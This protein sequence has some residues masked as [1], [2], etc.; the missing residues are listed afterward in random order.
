[1]YM[2][3]PVQS[4][5]SHWGLLVSHK[6]MS[7]QMWQPSQGTWQD[8]VDCLGAG[9]E[10]LGMLEAWHSEV[11][12]LVREVCW[13]D[14]QINT[15]PVHQWW[16]SQG[17]RQVWVDHSGAGG[18]R[19]G[20]LEVWHVRSCLACGV[21]WC[22]HKTNGGGVSRFK[23]QNRAWRWRRRT[24]SGLTVWVMCVEKLRSKGHTTWSRCLHRR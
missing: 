23:H 19:L 6:T 8:R 7:V 12:R 21:C 22:Y 20:V 17:M 5:V 15:K 9:S 18:E 1:M 14:Q 3:E 10:R 4:S 24:T 16:P 13:F 2:E 11:V